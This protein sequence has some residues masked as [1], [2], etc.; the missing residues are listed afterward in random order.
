M[1]HRSDAVVNPAW[2]VNTDTGDKAM[3][4]LSQIARHARRWHAN[5]KRAVME[6]TL[7]DLPLNLQKDIGWQAPRDHALGNRMNSDIHARPML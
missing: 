3:F 1:M 5:H 2:L 6:R 4:G 7:L